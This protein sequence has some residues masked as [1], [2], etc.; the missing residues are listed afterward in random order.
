MPSVTRHA[1]ASREARRAEARVRLLSAVEQLLADGESFTEMS[2]E[3]IVAE[4]GMARSTFYVYF[5][6]KGDLLGAWF[7]EITGELRSAAANW[8]KLQSPLSFGD[9]RHALA[10]IVAVY[11]PHTPLMAAVYDTS[12]YD[13][14]VRQLVAS[15]MS[16]NIAGLRAHIRHGQRG[17]LVDAQLH[18]AETAAWLTWMAERGFHQLVRGAPDAEVER[19]IDSYARIVWN[20]LYLPVVPGAR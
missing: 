4:A 7:A 10:A 15:M 9:V 2:V 3:R 1:P 13:P 5:A 8:W 11:R 19:L 20:T 18:P 16:E 6:D 12:A 14:T 17:G